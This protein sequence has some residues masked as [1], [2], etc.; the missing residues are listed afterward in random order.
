MFDTEI[1]TLQSLNTYLQKLVEGKLWLKVIIVLLLGVGFDLLLSPQNIWLSENTVDV[2]DNQAIVIPETIDAIRA[3]TEI[4]KKRRKLDYKN[5]NK[6]WNST[7]IYT[8][9]K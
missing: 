7:T 5:E 9:V 4:E 8:I 6:S 3:L 1:K 2:V